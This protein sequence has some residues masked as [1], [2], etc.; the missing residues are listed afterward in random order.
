M[1]DNNLIEDLRRLV[2]QCGYIFRTPVADA[3]Y[4]PDFSARGH[5]PKKFRYGFNAM[6][7]VRIV[8]NHLVIRK[9]K[10]IHAAGNGFGARNK[11][12]QR[13][14]DITGMYFLNK[15]GETSRKHISYIERSGSTKSNRKPAGPSDPE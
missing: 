12:H 2:C 11:T 1:P 3:G 10:H 8:N 4:H 13:F 7:I 6:W 15:C 9:L 5:R 14:Q